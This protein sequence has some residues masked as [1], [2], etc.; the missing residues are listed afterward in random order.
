MKK[1]IWNSGHHT[2]E[3]EV[4]SDPVKSTVGCKPMVKIKSID[5]E[6]E[7]YVLEEDLIYETNIK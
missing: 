1:A 4:K 6:R 5:G 2:E 3:V 7:R